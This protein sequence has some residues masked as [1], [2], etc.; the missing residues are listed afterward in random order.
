LGPDD[1]DTAWSTGNLA[2]DYCAQGKHAQVEALFQVALESNP[3]DPLTLSSL[4]WYLL[5]L[6][7]RRHR[8][9]QEALQ[10]ARR[11]VKGGRAVLT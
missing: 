7:D 1:K 6:P 10:L 11:A 3:N 9:P 4:V 2:N 8:R 5:V